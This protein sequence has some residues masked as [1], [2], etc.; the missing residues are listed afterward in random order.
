MMHYNRDVMSDQAKTNDEIKP[1]P[2]AKP[3]PPPS[4]APRL[5]IMTGLA[6]GLWSVIR[7]PFKPEKD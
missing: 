6:P 7:H 4:K 2:P 3:L 1:M 5:S